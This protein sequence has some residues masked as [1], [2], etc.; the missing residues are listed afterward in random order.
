MYYNLFLKKEPRSSCC[1][2]IKIAEKFYFD[3]SVNFMVFFF[4]YSV[5]ELSIF[6]KD[7]NVLFF[8]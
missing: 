6:V 8:M 5:L 1:I 2:N 7:L 4:F 3:S